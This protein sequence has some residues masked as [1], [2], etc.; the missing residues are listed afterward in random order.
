MVGEQFR[1]AASL[2]G[3]GH[4][5]DLSRASRG[6]CFTPYAAALISKACLKVGSPNPPLATDLHPRQFAIAQE[7][8]NGLEVHA[9]VVR[10]LFRG[11][12]EIVGI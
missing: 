7:S 4:L 11:H 12:E 9:Q 2:T 8:I 3:I 1:V 6:E 5:I 10:G